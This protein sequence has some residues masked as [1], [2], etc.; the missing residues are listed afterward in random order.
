VGAAPRTGDAKRV[1]RATLLAER[2]ALP[3]T[4]VAD[5]SRSIVT[6]LTALPELAGVRDVLLY[7]AD[8]D[9]VDLDALLAAPPSGW[10]ILLPR[11]ERAAAGTGG[12]AEVVPVMH[13]PGAPLLPGYR[14]IREPGG[15]AVDLSVV[16]AVIVPGVAFGPEGTRLGRGAGMY[17]RLLPRL[18]H[19]VH[20][21]VCLET[22]VRTGLPTEDHDA[23]VDLVVT[24]AS[25]RRRPRIA[26]P[27]PA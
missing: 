21:G 1:L 3:P 26:G 17:D 25:V 20:I 5:A 13:V 19:A 27:R 2:R 10:R 24:D 15:D 9:E 18:A 12:G 14:G 6:T 8:P 16:E 7:A 23:S 22:F 4:A 11:V